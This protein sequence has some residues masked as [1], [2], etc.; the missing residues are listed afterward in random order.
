MIPFAK[1]EIRVMGDVRD[2]GVVGK[3]FVLE[4]FIEVD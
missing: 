3:K 2:L 1:T 4:I